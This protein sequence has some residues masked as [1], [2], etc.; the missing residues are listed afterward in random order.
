MH[1]PTAYLANL[2]QIFAISK[3]IILNYDDHQHQKTS[4][5][6]YRINSKV[7]QHLTLFV[8]WCCCAGEVLFEKVCLSVVYK[9][10]LHSKQFLAKHFRG[11]G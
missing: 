9:F 7:N 1:L 11:I 2:D 10:V 5:A 3:L 4:S 6:I 8:D